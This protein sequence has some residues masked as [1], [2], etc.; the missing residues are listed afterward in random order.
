MSENAEL[1]AREGEELQKLEDYCKRH[2]I[3]IS[4]DLDVEDLRRLYIDK[5]CGKE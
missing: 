4:D 3:D 5:E 1:W 2:N